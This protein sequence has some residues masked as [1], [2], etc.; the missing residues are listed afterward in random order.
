[1]ATYAM[2]PS[3][4]TG[5]VN[6]TLAIAGELT[7]RDHEVTYYLPEE[8]RAQV[9]A[10]G[11]RLAPLRLDV[12]HGYLRAPDPVAR[13]ASVPVWLTAEAERVLPQVLQELDGSRPDVVV[14][15]M[16]CVWGRLLARLLPG[17]A[18]MVVGSY[19]GN[20][21]FSPM[22]TP[23]YA[24]MK[25][26]LASGF[27]EVG[28]AVARINERYGLRVRAQELF[29]RDEQLVMVVMPRQFHP[30]GD[31]FEE[32]FLF[33]GACLREEDGAEGAA[34]PGPVPG[35]PTVYVSFGTVV[36][37]G[38]EV[39]DT[40]RAAFTDGK[41][42]VVMV[43]GDQ[44]VDRDALPDGFT[45]HRSVP[46][47]RLLSRTDVFVTHGGTNSVMEALV[48]EVPMVV[49]ARAPE[50]AITADR[51]AELSL[52]VRLDPARLTA[53][54]LRRAVEHAASDHGVRDALRR[55]GGAVRAAGGHEAA[56]DALEKLL[57]GE[58]AAG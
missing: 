30:A 56:A 3:P 41:W 8:F 21:H 18:A 16:T 4:M 47:L 32:P 53:P 36:G 51:V 54:E 27:A 45:V 39:V 6:P 20:E 7:R 12:A 23:H 48:H 19:V 13:F 10:V 57:T 35:R 17:P 24:A 11:A 33:L 40:V 22:R 55:M 43:V 50:H 31:T 42:Q 15:D 14:Y 28:A 34:L 1:M 5:H 26:H 46:Q 29:A 52:G 37:L 25:E 38:D 44:S 2:F 9:E 49:V 58:P